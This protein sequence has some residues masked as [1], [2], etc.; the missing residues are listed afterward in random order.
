MKSEK[1]TSLPDKELKKESKKPYA[2][3]KLTVHGT[4]EKITKAGIGKRAEVLDT[5]SAGP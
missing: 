1:Q 3:P 4:V 2:P 5:G